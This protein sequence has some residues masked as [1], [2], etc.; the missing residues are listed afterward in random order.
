VP[1]SPQAEAALMSANVRDPANPSVWG[2]L[3]LQ[4]LASSTGV[5]A[6]RVPQAHEALAHALSRELAD[7]PLLRELGN[8]FYGLEQVRSFF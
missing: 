8:A 7:A 1:S 6:S 3:A 5:G 2:Y 4:C